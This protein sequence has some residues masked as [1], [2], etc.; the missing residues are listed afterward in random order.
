[1]N[2]KEIDGL[3]AFLRKKNRTFTSITNWEYI[4]GQWND[5]NPDQK[6]LPVNID[7][8]DYRSDMNTIQEDKRKNK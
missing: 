1:M 5:N 6:Q 4:V 7:I 2:P 8:P 3:I